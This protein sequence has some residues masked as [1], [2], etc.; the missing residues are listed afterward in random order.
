[1][2]R[3]GDGVYTLGGENFSVDWE[4]ESSLYGDGSTDLEFLS[5]NVYDAAGNKVGLTEEE[6]GELE[7]IIAWEEGL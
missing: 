1:M 2:I 7:S 5:L 4:A 3:R 6:E